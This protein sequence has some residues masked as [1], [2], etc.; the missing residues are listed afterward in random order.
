[1]VKGL[2]DEAKQ[3]TKMSEAVNDGS[4]LQYC[5]QQNYGFVFRAA[6]AARCSKQ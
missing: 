6:A 2:N 4:T 5:R 1:M 3:R